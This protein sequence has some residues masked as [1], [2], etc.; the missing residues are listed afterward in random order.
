MSP[1]MQLPFDEPDEARDVSGHPPCIYVA[2]KIT[3]TTP[4][5]PERQMIQFA[6]SAITEA[7]T[8][9]T[10]QAEAPWQ[11]RVHAPVEWT[12]PERTPRMRPGEIFD[13]NARHVLNEADALIVY[14]WSPSAGVG[15]EITWAA[16]TLGLPVLYIQ[17]EGH[18]ASR[19]VA[20]T[21]GD[22]TVVSYTTPDEL[23]NAVCCWVRSRR[24][25]IEASPGRRAS[26]LACYVELHARLAE[27]WT[28]ADEPDRER[29]AAHLGLTPSL[30]A[31]WLEDPAFLSVAPASHVV[32]L[33]AE[34]T[35]STDAIVGRHE[36]SI[37]ELEALLTARDEHQWEEATV[38]RLRRRGEAELARPTVRRFKLDTPADWARLHE[39]MNR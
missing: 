16:L 26:R 6:V 31:W 19:Q 37:A 15:Q 25:Q 18:P 13:Q 33:T 28:K 12:T 24:H 30:I 9:A 23:K 1:G 35:G 2:S 32:L 21:P 14:G 10:E 5:S 7:T 17:P 38:Q 22:L 34:L 29:V 8:E 20:G 36:L 3:G 27:A 11:L 39:A 4:A